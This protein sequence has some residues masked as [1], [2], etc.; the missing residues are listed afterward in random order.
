[1]VEAN[2]LRG[3]PPLPAQAHK[4]SST[5]ILTSRLRAKKVLAG[6]PFSA[7]VV[8]RRYWSVNLKEV[9]RR[10]IAQG[11]KYLDG[12]RFTYEGGQV[13]SL[14]SLLSYFGKGEMRERSFGI[15]IPP[16]NLKPDFGDQ[17]PGVAQRTGQQCHGQGPD[18]RVRRQRIVLVG[19]LV[20]FD[21][22]DRVRLVVP[23]RMCSE[24]C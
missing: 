22:R 6:K 3:R 9:K 15:K 17:A 14:L 8:C 5:A 23:M 2:R 1:M 24:L 7:Y 12:I 18:T 13:R 10:G 11:G 16:T 20:A 4:P 19:L 21:R